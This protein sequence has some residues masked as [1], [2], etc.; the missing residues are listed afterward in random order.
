MADGFYDISFEVEVQRDLVM[1]TEVNLGEDHSDNDGHGN[2]GD[3][4]SDTQKNLDAMETDV[5]HNRQDQEGSKN[6]AS[7]GPDINKLAGD[8]SSGVKFSPTVKHMMEQSK[9]EIAAFIKSLAPSVVASEKSLDVAAA[10]T[11]TAQ[12]PSAVGAA[13][14]EDCIAATLPATV[15]GPAA[16]DADSAAGAEKCIAAAQPAAVEV[17]AVFGDE[18]AARADIPAATPSAASVPSATPS[19]AMAAV[20]I[21][22]PAVAIDAAVVSDIDGSRAEGAVHASPTKNS[23]H[24][25]LECS[26]T[27]L[28]GQK[29]P[30]SPLFAAKGPHSFLQARETMGASVRRLQ[31]V[32]LLDERKA[33]RSVKVHRG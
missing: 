19:T 1:T 28:R 2:N 13:G 33:R 18:S 7:N 9:I 27:F 12:A 29:T 8:F 25:S 14:A 32:H 11:N 26:R 21:M 10:T 4:A 3:S 31:R 24:A 5:A 23:F 17:Q 20:K 30:A 6:A 15:D 22:A 16:F